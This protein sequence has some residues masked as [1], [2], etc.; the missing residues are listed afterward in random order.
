MFKTLVIAS[1]LV[2]ASTAQ[3]GS[4]SGST[5]D[6]SR[7]NSATNACAVCHTRTSGL[8]TGAA[9]FTPYTSTTMQAKGGGQPGAS[10]KL[11]LACHDGVLASNNFKIAGKSNLGTNLSNDHPIGI[12]YDDGLAAADGSL[13]ATTHNV[14]IGAGA[15]TKSGTIAVSMLS[16]GKMECTTCHDVHNTF[17]ADGGKGLIKVSMVQSSLCTTCHDK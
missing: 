9:V 8:E 2:L 1:A 14:T 13:H 10:S 12:V 16:S 6:F 7:G 17:T 3:A 4:F 5:H 15:Q 11:C